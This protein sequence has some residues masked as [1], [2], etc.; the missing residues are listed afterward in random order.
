[1]LWGGKQY[2][3]KKK[4]VQLNIFYFPGKPLNTALLSEY[5]FCLF[6]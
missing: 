3:C 2:I 1:L 4:G 6:G 5:F